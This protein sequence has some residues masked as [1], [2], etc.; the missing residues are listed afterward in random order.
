[1]YLRPNSKA[2][3]VVAAAC[4]YHSLY[5]MPMT[6]QAVAGM[7]S[8]SYNTARKWLKSMEDNGDIRSETVAVD[9]GVCQ[10]ITIYYFDDDS[11]AFFAA[12]L[13]GVESLVQYRFPF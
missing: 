6:A 10:T 13:W 8:V 9:M 3:E 7:A 1:M 12:R 4:S 2:R 11:H 5:A